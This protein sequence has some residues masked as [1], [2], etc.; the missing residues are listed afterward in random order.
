MRSLLLIGCLCVGA[1][2][3]FAQDRGTITGTLTDPA[4]AVVA[5]AS[6]EA[7]NQET[8]LTYQG[9]STSTGSYTIV[10]LPVGVYEI[11]AAVPGFKKY[12]R[13]G[14]T[15]EVA[16]ILRIDIPLEVGGS[17]ESITV[18]A[19]APLLRTESGDISHSVTVQ[20]MDDLPILGIGAGQA[21][22]AGIRNPY[23]V[24]QLIPGTM[25]QANA[26]VRVNGAPNN[27]QSFR[28]EGQDASNTG[29]P[30]V[31]AQTQPSVDAIQEVA[32]QTSNYAPE[33]GQVGGGMFN[34]TMKS[35][36][37]QLH[38]SGYE[39]FVNEVFNAGE[40]FY[41]GNAAGNPRPRNRRN[42]YGFTVGGPVWIP[43]IYNGKNRTFF[44]FNFEQYREAVAINNQEETVPTAAYRLGNFSGALG[45]QIGTDPL[46]RPIFQNEI[47][48]PTSNQTVAGQ[49]VRN[50]FANNM[51]PQTMW[52]PVAQK[53]QALFPQPVGPFA[54]GAINNYIPNI[55]TTRVTTIPSFKIDQSIGAA[56]KISFF[57]QETKTT[58]PLSFTFGQVDGLPDPLATNAGTFQHAFVYR[59]NY[60]HTLSP[61][62]LFHFGL[63]YRSNY[64]FVPTVN[65]EGQIPNYNAQAELGLN[66]G[67]T[68][69]FFPAFS[70]L[71]TGAGGF[72]PYL[73]TNLGGGMQNFGA[74]ASADDVTQAETANSSLTWVKNNH[75]F[76]FGAE[77]RVEGYPAYVAS[78]TAGSYTFAS[79]QTSQPYLNGTTLKGLTPGFA[80]A[81]FLLGDVKTVS[82]TNP[83]V[84]RLGKHEL[85]FY[86][87]DSF[88]VSRKL[89]VD[90]GV[91]YDYSTYLQ[92]EHGRDTFFSPTT[93]DPAVG[94][95]PGAVI[96]EGYGTGKCNC[97]LAKNYPYGFAPRLGVAYQV[98]PKTVIRGGFG[99]I[100]GNTASNNNIAASLAGSTNT[101]TAP[102]FGAAV[103][104]LSTGIPASFN[105]LP[106]PNLNPGQFNTTTT[107]VA[108]TTPLVP[109]LDP[110]SGRPPRQY[111][112]SIGVQR[113]I[114][115][116][117]VAEATYVGNR[118]IWWQAP[119]LLNINEVSEAKL[120]S[121]GLTAGSP[122][123]TM[124]L[125]SPQVIA[126]GLG[127]P[128]Y[129][130]F[131]VTQTL[132]QALRPFP[133]F[134]TIDSIWDPL[135]DT[136]YQA[137]QTKLTKR[138]S[139]GLSAL[140]TFTWAKSED[141][142]TE[143][144]EPNP[145]T[146]GNAVVNDPNNRNLDKYLSE[147]D[148][149]FVLNISVTYVT[150]KINGGN[151]ILSYIA[152][153]WTYG[154]F[155]SYSSGMPIQV[156]FANNNLNSDIFAATPGG[157]TGTTGTF[158]DRVPGVPLFTVDPNC[159]CYD[160]NK[161]FLL[162]PA[163]W[164][165][166]QPGQFGYSAAY[167]SDYREQRRPSEN[168][169]LGRTWR[170]KERMAFNMRIEFYNIFN[171][172]Y[173]GN[174]SASN[175][176]A[177]QSHQPNG[178]AA[179]GFGFMNTLTPGFTGAAQPRNG[180]LVA[181]F[182]F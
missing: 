74:D 146:T 164:T 23:A 20:A 11:S 179:S 126:A 101:V 178:N 135:G 129:P 58:A 88:K 78:G 60:D 153:D 41:T 38:G 37:N 63:G 148:Q 93:P 139:H 141:L 90:Y 116:N 14:I 56:A 133:Q 24:T 142:G 94:G 8:G 1:V 171:R 166:P 122:L 123:L 120:A 25:W 157:V 156:P 5:N 117:L 136:W 113:E 125:N 169:N 68:H 150:P 162:N 130:G 62:L 71:C 85:G 87:Q 151:K 108:L 132:A 55:P 69:T 73:C 109:F 32:I 45:P 82:V 6:V 177:T 138:F 107:P 76:K 181:R 47:Y 75:T 16:A 121:L 33:Y 86:A 28:I 97:Q 54:N 70:G 65:E 95:I 72:T 27:T 119:G 61:T 67:T 170:F 43:K 154:A 10:Q 77:V 155:L 173:W 66:G 111:Q 145:G 30:G 12:V 168:M 127:N 99:I 51:I 176:Q 91:R 110:N 18:Q 83:V 160:P 17:T 81:S 50:P 172:A 106:W 44:F 165:N 140:A 147:Y 19:D 114:A 57:Y 180:T 36:T 92:E 124:R 105:P 9:A 134:T 29:T 115:T 102:S 26:Q 4:G 2:A 174:P 163:A 48:N 143:I 35:G 161:T 182:T 152:R 112:W 53:I 52:D 159:H 137:L 103:T 49:V 21:G 7:K 131:P 149:P 144:G 158:A 39:N 80:Y 59:G 42:D 128:P 167:Y 22:S 64:F 100:Y 46:N 13:T 118:G 98:T 34:V 40:P 15:V 84:P 3:L 175:F 31:P 96:F 79:D 104:T 89:T